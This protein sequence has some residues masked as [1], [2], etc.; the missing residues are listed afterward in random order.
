MKQQASQE[1]NLA[2][3]QLECVFDILPDGVVAC[4][5]EEKILRINA[6]ALKLFEVTSEASCKGK[7]YQQFLHSY[8]IHDE[9]QGLTSLEPWLSSLIIGEEASTQQQEETVVI[10]VPSER[11]SYVTIRSLSVPDAQKCAI[12]V[13][14]VFYD[15]TSRYQKAL[16]IQRVHRAVSRLK[17]AIAHLPVHID[18]TFPEEL[19][20]LS[21]PVIFIA[22][23]LVDVIGEV[24]DYKTVSLLAIAPQA[25]HLHYAVGNGFT[26]EQEHHRR[27]VSGRFLPSDFVDETALASLAANQVVLLP[28]NRLHLPAGFQGD[29]DTKHLLIPLFLEQQLA[30]GLV[31]ARDDRDSQYTPEEIELVKVVA[32]EAMLVIEYILSLNDHAETRARVVAEQEMYASINDFLNLASHELNTPLTV[33][34]GNIQLA[35]RR[36][37]K[38]KRQLLEQPEHANEK[39]EG[40]LSP[41]ASAAASARLEE[42]I[43][44]DLI[45][46]ARIQNNT[47][48]FHMQRLD[49]LML[50]RQAV[51]NEQKLA[52]DRTIELD[53]ESAEQA[54][55][56]IADA[57][58]ITQVIHGYLANALRYSPADQPVTVQLTVE[59]GIAHVSV[60]DKG[61]GL[62]LEE[63]ERIWERFYYAREAALEYEPDPGSGLGLYLCRVFIE[64]H[65]GSVGVKSDPGHGATFWF[66]LPV[67]SSTER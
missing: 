11:K 31:I 51:A 17:E 35:Q 56:V 16:H 38:L 34:K 39:I 45:D 64:R 29:S 30:G 8:E 47:I 6:A 48:E 55:P 7:S 4:D 9:Q 27:K 23:Q 13:V 36:L 18:F 57:E 44:K 25:G 15:I 66:T 65:H 43:I 61:P 32:T 50:L 62:P 20:L 67:E 24:L 12:A 21:P 49:L 37:A 26:A 40:I 54:V 19:F 2:S 33:I 5:R 63:Q 59:D 3:G 46:D 41:L 28:A 52:P 60:H 1:R 22:Q 42:Q 14:N 58:R 10:Q 53:L